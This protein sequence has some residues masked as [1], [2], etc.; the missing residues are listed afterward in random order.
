VE[1]LVLVKLESWDG[2]GFRSEMG[3]GELF[4]S[5]GFITILRGELS[6]FCYAD[7][8]TRIRRDEPSVLGLIGATRIWG[9]L[10]LIPL[11]SLDEI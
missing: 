7:F 10:P 2:I 4:F 11:I 3:K 1:V 8:M 5:E 6:N 9:L